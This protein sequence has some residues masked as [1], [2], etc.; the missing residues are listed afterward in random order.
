[1]S[2]A[3]QMLFEHINEKQGLSQNSVHAITQDEQGFLWLGTDDGLNRFD[4]YSFDI[5]RSDDKNTEAILPGKIV[6]LS[7]YHTHLA[8]LTENGISLIHIKSFI[9]KNYLF[10]KNIF[11][12]KIIYCLGNLI[13]V[14]SDDG[15]FILNATTGKFSSTPI[16]EPV[17]GISKFNQ[18]KLLISISSGF[19][20]YYPFNQK[21]AAITYEPVSFIKGFACG[22]NGELSWVE[23]NGVVQTG[24]IKKRTLIAYRKI[25]FPELNQFTSILSYQKYLL[26]STSL[27]LF[28]I[29]STG[30]KTAY[31]NNPDEPYSLSDNHVK[32]LY[33][34]RN[35]NLWL[36]LSL[37]GLDKYHPN[38][39]K[40]TWIGPGISNK[41]NQFKNLLSFIECNNGHLIYA[42]AAGD[43]GDFDPITHQT[44]ILLKTDLLI[45]AITPADSNG[46][47]FILGTSV[48][49]YIYNSKR[50][51]LKKLN[52][53][54]EI[55]PITSDVKSILKWKE[56]VFWLAGEEGL[57]LYD[58]KKEKTLE[59]YGIGNSNLGS[60]NIRMILLNNPKELLLTTAAGLYKLNTTTKFISPVKLTEEKKEPFFS[61]IAKDKFGNI[62]LGS[63]NQGIYKLTPQ[64]LIQKINTHNGL[65]NNNIYGILI[66]DKNNEI[67]FSTNAGLTRLQ[68]LSNTLQ[69]F[70]IHD[71][72]QGNEFI[73]SS[74]IKTR[75]GLF[76]FGGI[77]GFNLF[78]PELIKE[79]T[80][81]CKVSIKELLI[82]DKEVA[83]QDYYYLGY[84]DNYLTFEFV[85]L[86]FSFSASNRYYYKMD[87]L[88][89][90]WNDAGNRRF[91]SFGHMLP[92]NYIFKV[93]ASNGDNHLSKE[94]AEIC[95]SI[96]P[97]F[98]QTWWFKICI[99][100]VLSGG[101]AFLIY[102]NLNKII[103]EEQEKTRNIKTI[104]ELELKALRAQMNPHFIFNS[105]NSIQDFVLNN[106]GAQAAKYLSKFAKLMR[107]ILDISEHP[108][109]NIHIKLSFLKL[110]VELE[111]L[112][113]NNNFTFEFEIDEEINVDGKIPTLLIQPYIENAIWHGLQY[114]Q[115]EKFLKIRMVS[116][117]YDLLRCELE[118][119]GIG[120]E[121]A[122]EIKKNKSTLHQ[123]KGVKIADERMKILK[124]TFGSNPKIEIIDLKD[125]N[126]LACGTKVVLQ[127][128]IKYE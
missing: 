121:A 124:R 51:V 75:K 35:Q 43:L 89:E 120:R 9:S 112:R 107:I 11:K 63:V 94:I 73:E 127:I 55:K 34:D 66:D 125:K 30:E 39:F 32:C 74:A 5:F 113:M 46:N 126:N 103:K 50:N 90:N 37:A 21:F 97:P 102:Y 91:A 25:E 82:N 78:N 44:N 53:L 118:D 98:W 13:L 108:F 123:S 105:L 81:N 57:F 40:F 45:N 20:F 31:H 3:Q 12:P 70:D 109:V 1:M 85:A 61:Q 95:I 128:P 17:T 38:R 62:W 116:L 54:N 60:N 10:P 22:D 7:S 49:V 18:G 56:N 110:Y 64:K 59:Y 26:V 77:N 84:R 33:S 117:S 115:G 92:G 80:I 47:F 23:A 111:A 16:S 72:L 27:G 14:G 76:V 93:R 4:G 71:G 41:Y 69:N 101:I 42:I 122:L 24:F 87:G 86:D 83:Y 65:G 48:G 15:L 99:F 28:K 88:Q 106:E 52:T 114:K 8:V 36:G 119:N 79:D 2:N 68:P 100:I 96:I 19:Y 58:I 29:D 6:G 104:A 67:W